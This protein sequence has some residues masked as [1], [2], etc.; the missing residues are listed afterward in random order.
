MNI[1]FLLTNLVETKPAESDPLVLKIMQTVSTVAKKEV[2]ESLEPV[3]N[4]SNTKTVAETET[5]E[6]LTVSGF[7]NESAVELIAD[8]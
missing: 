6:T 4:Q 3:T 5:V 1:F 7:V 2:K 8:L